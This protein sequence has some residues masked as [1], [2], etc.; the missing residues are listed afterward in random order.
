[1]CILREKIYLI[2]TSSDLKEHPGSKVSEISSRIPDVELTEVRKMT[3]SMVGE[4]LRTEGARTNRVYY[5][6]NG[7]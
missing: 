7:R 2:F 3:Y 1:M 5:L 4:D 6:K